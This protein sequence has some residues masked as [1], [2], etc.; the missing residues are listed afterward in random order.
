[1]NNEEVPAIN[2][3]EQP[4]CDSTIPSTSDSVRAK[5]FIKKT[6]VIN[7][8][9]TSKCSVCKKTMHG[10][11][12][13]RHMIR[14]HSA[15]LNNNQV[16]KVVWDER[17]LKDYHKSVSCSVCK[18]TMRSDHLKRHITAKH[19]DVLN[20]TEHQM[21]PSD[22]FTCKPATSGKV[23]C[24]SYDRKVTNATSFALT[25]VTSAL[26]WAFKHVHD[27]T[28]TFLERSGERDASKRITNLLVPVEEY[29]A[30]MADEELFRIANVLILR[31]EST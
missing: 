23:Y 19:N 20:T 4:A 2:S 15:I 6:T 25:T 3:N 11:S 16:K 26:H 21:K 9:K 12:L 5:K 13:K 14:K 27:E 29:L 17:P 1:M 22:V 7:R 28:V 18:K 31:A 24:K 8:R 10:N 30:N